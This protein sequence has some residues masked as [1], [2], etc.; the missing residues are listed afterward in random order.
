M[1]RGHPDYNASDYEIAVSSVDPGDLGVYLGHPVRIDGKG[2]LAFYDNF[3]RGDY[4][5]SLS[6]TNMATDNVIVCDPPN[7]NEHGVACQF[8]PVNSAQSDIIRHTGV[9]PA[10]LYTGLEFSHYGDPNGGSLLAKLVVCN[11]AGL[12][13]YGLVEMLGANRGIILHHAGGTETIYWPA[14]PSS[15]P[16]GFAPVKIVLDSQS[17]YYRRLYYAGQYF[18]V[19]AYGLLYSGYAFPG[20]FD[21]TFTLTGTTPATSIYARLG[22]IAVTIDEP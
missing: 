2:R 8:G 7:V 17:G 4:R 1:A 19:S 6:G 13:G 15:V 18:D 12:A 22:Y 5:W 20:R 16:T 21:V 11:S 14:S 9:I 10:T 3:S